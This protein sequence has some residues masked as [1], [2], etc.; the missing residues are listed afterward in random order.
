MGRSGLTVSL[1]LALSPLL[2]P[3][4]A[5]QAQAV[6]PKSAGSERLQPPPPPPPLSYKELG[7]IY[8]SEC[9]GKPPKPESRAFCECSFAALSSR[10]S[11][12]QFSELDNL[13][14]RGPPAIRRFAAIAW[15]PEFSRCR[16]PKKGANRP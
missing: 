4:Y 7:K 15:E 11:A 6:A 5:S 16:A 10:Y 3:P 1:A 9:Q 12:L 8:L 2:F 14:R 13:I